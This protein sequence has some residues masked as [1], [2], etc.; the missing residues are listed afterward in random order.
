[1]NLPG[2]DAW[3]TREP[4][5]D[6]DPSELQEPGPCRRCNG[7]GWI[8]VSN[9]FSGRYLG[10]GPVPEYARGARDARCDACGGSGEIEPPWDEEEEP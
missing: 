2:Y 8:A 4:D 3:L 7:S 1:M 9:G 6:D 5:W 10:P